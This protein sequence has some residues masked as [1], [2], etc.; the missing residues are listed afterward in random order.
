MC[1][2]MDTMKASFAEVI[3]DSQAS[4]SRICK[5][6]IPELRQSMEKAIQ[7]LRYKFGIPSASA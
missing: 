2:S 1:E 7:G 6:S 5:A 3:A 4:A